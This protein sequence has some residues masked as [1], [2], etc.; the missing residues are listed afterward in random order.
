LAHNKLGNF[1]LL[2]KTMQRAILG[3]GERHRKERGSGHTVPLEIFKRGSEGDEIVTPR[4]NARG[5]GGYGVVEWR[6]YRKRK[7]VVAGEGEGGTGGEIGGD[8]GDELGRVYNL[9]HRESCSK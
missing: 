2:L 5:V 1:L 8:Q 9:L 7:G 3:R 4:P 6:V